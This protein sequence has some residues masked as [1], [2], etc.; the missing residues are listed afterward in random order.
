M[1]GLAPLGGVYQAGTLSGNPLATAAGLATLSLLDEDAYRQ[2]EAAAASLQHGLEGAFEE[3]FSGSTMAAV[4]PRVGPLLGL[5]F[6]GTAPANFDEARRAA[7]NGLYPKFFHGMLSRGVA[8]A[9]GAYEAI[10][11]S[12]AHTEAEINATV[13]AAAETAAEMSATPES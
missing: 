3:A 11:V 10:F 1:S 6:T 4:V 12:L 8:F 2:L 7:D 9:P 13:A 5:F